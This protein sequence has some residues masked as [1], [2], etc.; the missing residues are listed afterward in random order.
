MG[1]TLEKLDDLRARGLLTA[2]CSVLDFGPSN[3]YSASEDGI[4][5]FAKVHDATIPRCMTPQ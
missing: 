4:R 3:L 1:I 5:K 2:G